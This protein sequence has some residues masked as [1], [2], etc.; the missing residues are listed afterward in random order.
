MLAAAENDDQRLKLGSMLQLETETKARLR[1]A[2]FALGLSVVENTAMREQAIATAESL[3]GASWI[4]KMTALNHEL[5]TT[6]LPALQRTWLAT[7]QQNAQ[8]TGQ[9]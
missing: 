8:A 4:E 7:T 9:G 6:F 5:A 1:P 2:M 3:A